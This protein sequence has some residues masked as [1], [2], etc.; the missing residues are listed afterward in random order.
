MNIRILALVLAIATWGPL[1]PSASAQDKNP[2]KPPQFQ[3][4][5][6]DW[7]DGTKTKSTDVTME[8]TPDAL[9][10]WKAWANQN[11]SKPLIHLPY[12]D[13]TG[14]QTGGTRSTSAAAAFVP[15]ALATSDS[16]WVTIKTVDEYFAFRLAA[17][18]YQLILA[19][20]EQRTK[21]VVNGATSEH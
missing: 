2:P 13:I 10:V 19:E 4:V 21:L 3:E 16:R 20:L 8:F 12:R 18:N 14:L 17:K 11:K 5:F 9:N 15:P 1:A 6:W 7:Q